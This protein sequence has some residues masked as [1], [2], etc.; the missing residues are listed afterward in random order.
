MNGRVG[1]GGRWEKIPRGKGKFL[2]HPPQIRPLNSWLFC[3]CTS[4]IVLLFLLHT[5]TLAFFVFIFMFSSLNRVFYIHLSTIWNSS[6]FSVITAVSSAN[7]SISIFF[8]HSALCAIVFYLLLY[9]LPPGSLFCKKWHYIFNNILT[10]R[11][12]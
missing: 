12:I 2:R 10:K 3:W 9:Q 5:R 8:C 11:R 7:C 6:S 1:R 4:A